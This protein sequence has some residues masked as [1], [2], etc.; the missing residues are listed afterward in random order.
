MFL[1]RSDNHHSKLH[2]FCSKPRNDF[3]KFGKSFS[4][5]TDIIQHQ[6]M[7]TFEH[8]QIDFAVNAENSF[9]FS[10]FVRGGL[11]KLNRHW[12][13]QPFHNIRCEHKGTIEYPN[14]QKPGLWFLGLDLLERFV[15]LSCQCIQMFVNLFNGIDSL[16]LKIQTLNNVFRLTL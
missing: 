3:N 12:C 11:D 8:I 15:D 13:G 1:I 2:R 9:A 4:C 6:D 16:E 7:S 5:V 14:N 10:A